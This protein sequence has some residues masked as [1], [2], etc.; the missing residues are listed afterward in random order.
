LFS[1]E[2]VA[3]NA[4]DQPIF[5]GEMHIPPVSYLEGPNKGKGLLNLQLDMILGSLA[6]YQHTRIPVSIRRL[7]EEM[8]TGRKFCFQALTKTEER[9]KFIDFTAATMLTFPNALI[10]SRKNQ[11]KF[12]PYM[13]S[14]GSIDLQAMLDDQNL[15]LAD[16]EGRSYSEN[17]GKI[18]GPYRD[19][20][21]KLLK[22]KS[23]MPDWSLT[24]KQVLHNRL[25]AMIGRP[26]EVYDVAKRLNMQ[27]DLLYLP[28]KNEAK[29]SLI[30]GGCS[31]GNWNKTYLKDLNKVIVQVRE[32]PDFIQLRL[33]RI[34]QSLH[35]QYLQYRKAAMSGQFPE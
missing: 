26:G 27:A 35:E 24:V 21:S 23:G 22:V 17:I 7:M 34:P 3:S 33:E 12:Q 29:Y 20:K 28:I 32:K 1:F 16:F 13:T 2:S 18:L 9:A 11:A 5:W 19:Q 6:A 30:Y 8:K 15:T 25:D 31:K 14:D 10:T 4:S